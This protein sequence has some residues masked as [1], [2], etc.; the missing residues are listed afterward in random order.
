MV[1][2]GNEYEEMNHGNAKFKEEYKYEKPIAY[3]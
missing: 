3:C 1:S 2:F